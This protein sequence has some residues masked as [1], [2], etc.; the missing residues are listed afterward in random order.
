M[1]DYQK[2][3][4]PRKR[5]KCACED[6][7]VEVVFVSQSV[8][9]SLNHANLV[10]EPFDKAE[11]HFVLWLAVGRDPFPMPLDQRG[12]FLERLQP[13]PLERGAPLLKELAGP[14]LAAILPELAE[15]LLQDIRGI[16][17]LVRREQRLHP[18]AF[19]RREIRAVREQRVLL[20]FD[21]GPLGT[22][23]DP[24]VL[25]LSP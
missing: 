13:L 4:G 6:L 21:V 19:L 5:R 22:V 15:L 11:R 12:E 7:E 3:S 16:E 14:G 1:G 17:P 9:P 18:S 2:K 10:V 20:P 25:R 8:A 24:F 23:G